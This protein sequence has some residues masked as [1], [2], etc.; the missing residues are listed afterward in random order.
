MGIVKLIY[1]AVF[2]VVTVVLVVLMLEV[3]GHFVCEEHLASS[4]LCT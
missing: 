3:P 2:A 4:A 1:F